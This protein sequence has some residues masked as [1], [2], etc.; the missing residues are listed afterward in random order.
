M[1]GNISFHALIAALSGAVIEAQDS[2]NLHQI[3]NLRGYFDDD[4][5]PKSVSFR[6]PSLHP[7]AQEGDEDLYRA[8]LLPLVSTN[9]LRIKDVE[10][11]FEA[12][13]GELA[14][15]PV[16]DASTAASA[17]QAWEAPRA[18]P[19]RIG[20]DTARP[21]NGGNVRVVLRVEGTDPADGTARLI[22]QLAQS[23]GVV[24]TL[25]AT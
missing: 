25:K 5:R 4:N 11:S 14:A 22:N 12:D 21:R 24:K 6:L 19:P 23:Q 13:L 2:I 10:I 3:A 18:V 7:T 20:V 16:P 8:P 1:S 15:D 9:Q 17:D